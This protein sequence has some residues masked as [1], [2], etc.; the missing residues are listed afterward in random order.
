ARHRV[1][2]RC[3]CAGGQRPRDVSGPRNDQASPRREN[4]RARALGGARGRAGQR[5]MSTAP[6]TAQPSNF[7]TR[8]RVVAALAGIAVGNHPAGTELFRRVW[9]D[10]RPIEPGDLF[11]AWVGERF[12]AHDFLKDAVEKGASGLVVS[13]VTSAT[14]LGVPVFEVSD[15]LA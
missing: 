10:T 1:A 7:W 13:R 15:T 12:D 14:G 4:H 8:D 9:T 3:H 6:P 11:V 5:V 2:G